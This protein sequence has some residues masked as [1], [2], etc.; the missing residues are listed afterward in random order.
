MTLRGSALLSAEG[1][2]TLRSRFEWTPIARDDVPKSLLAV[3]PDGHLLFSQK[4]NEGFVDNPTYANGFVV[5]VAGGDARKI[6][7]LSTN[8]DHPIE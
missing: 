5:T 6:F 2:K 1:F 7:F 4:L 8:M 3:L